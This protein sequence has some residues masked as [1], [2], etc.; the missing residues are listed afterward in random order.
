MSTPERDD[1][2]T[3]TERP[4]PDVPVRK[5]AQTG[6]RTAGFM[7]RSLRRAM[8]FDRPRFPDIPT[9]PTT[10][11]LLLGALADELLLA[12]MS[13]D[14]LV[15]SEHELRRI[16]AETRAAV[17]VIRR[18]GWLEDPTGYHIAP[19]AP[20]QVELE[21]KRFGR[22]RYDELTFDSGFEPVPDM[23]G[24]DRWRAMEANRV[25]HAYV[26]RHRG[27]TDRPWLVH[28]HGFSMG[29]PSDLEAF[30]SL[31]YHRDLGFNV[32]HPVLPLHGPRRAGKRSGD[33][34]IT[35][36]FLNNVHGMA[37][38]VWDVRRCIAWARSHGATSVVVHGVSLGAY[39][40]ALLSGLEP[41]LGGVIAGVPSVD[42][43]WVMRQHV[44]E[45]ARP[46]VDAHGILGELADQV[47]HV[48]SPLA[49]E[50][51]VPEDRRFIYAGVADRMAK[52]EA[53]HRL[54]EHWDE[55]SI[56]WYGG[57]HVGFA[58]SR[59]VRRFVGDAI[60]ASVAPQHP[61]M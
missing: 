35:L 27:A 37:Q 54:W 2:N 6:P 33:A 21:R 31:H 53:A 18:H 15:P 56:C 49:F 32:I 46:A 13:N 61:V 60:T 36:D 10:P 24:A 20:P 9:R 23:P 48:V 44:P 11:A 39:T 26:M 52:P 50:C 43:A 25:T 38:A 3:G 55:P 59:E 41:G 7:A 17:D 22:I 16:A 19:P 4:W 5:L 14:R 1:T 34:F 47:H 51:L 30:H 12:T 57:S 8:P 45:K 29:V 28:L 42:L 58:L 40:A